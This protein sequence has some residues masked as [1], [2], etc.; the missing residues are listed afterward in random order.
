MIICVEHSGVLE[1]ARVDFEEI[2]GCVGTILSNCRPDE[3]P[4]VI[5]SAVVIFRRARCGQSSIGNSSPIA[6]ENDEMSESGTVSA[7]CSVDDGVISITDCWGRIGSCTDEITVCSESDHSF[8]FAGIV[9][10]WGLLY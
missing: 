1:S 4:I 8:R 9:L 7:I 3:L 10:E 5:N 2:G 6:V